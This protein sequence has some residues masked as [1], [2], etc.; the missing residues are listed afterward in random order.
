MKPVPIL[1]PKG[2]INDEY[3]RLTTKIF[4]MYKDIYSRY[5][6]YDWY[7]KADMD[8]YVFVDNLRSFLKTKNSSSP[9]TFGYDFKRLVAHGYHSGGA[10]YVLSREALRRLGSELH[11]NKTFC[12]NHGTEDVDVGRCLRKLGVYP[13]KSIDENGRERFHPLSVKDHLKGH[14][15][16]WMYEYASNPLKNVFDIF[17]SFFKRLF[18]I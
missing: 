18:I 15:P 7:F 14:Y 6:Q 16:H 5:S 3:E 9:V 12:N 4:L 2:L 10:G 11:K 8:S 17:Y 1:Q 13:N